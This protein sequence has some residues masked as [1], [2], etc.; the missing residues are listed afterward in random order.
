MKKI[1]VFN[2][3][4]G[5]GKSTIARLFVERNRGFAY[6]PEIGG[7]LRREVSYNALHSKEDFDL[8]VMKREMARDKQLLIDPKTPVVETWHIGNMAYA[9]AR[10]PQLFEVYRGAI[11]KQLRLFEP[12]G[13]MLDITWDTFRSRITEKIGADEIDKLTAFYQEVLNNT[14]EAYKQ[15]EIPHFRVK[16]ED[17]PD[18]SIKIAQEELVQRGF[19]FEGRMGNKEAE[20]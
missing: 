2:G 10:N 11:T 19:L 16:N 9:L 17:F 20:V 18:E 4:H 12:T 8:E 15:F 1:L 7:Q 5:A 14:I 13:I 3:V 6:F